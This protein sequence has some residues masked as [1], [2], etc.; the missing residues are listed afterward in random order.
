MEGSGSHGS[1]CGWE[2]PGAVRDPWP[3]FMKA[4]YGAACRDTGGLSCGS[5]SAFDASY[6]AYGGRRVFRRGI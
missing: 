2:Y 1:S 5:L 3:D 4:S 6:S